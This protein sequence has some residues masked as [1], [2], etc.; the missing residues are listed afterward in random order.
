MYEKLQL[1]MNSFVMNAGEKDKAILKDVLSKIS[2]L[3]IVGFHHK[4]EL[5]AYS[6]S[7]TFDNT[8]TLVTLVIYCYNVGLDIKRERVAAKEKVEVK[9]TDTFTASAYDNNI[10]FL[11]LQIGLYHKQLLTEMN[12]L[13]R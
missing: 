9:R 1:A 4:G 5:E 2:S 11:S 3:T 7:L 12:K 13:N 6:K 10:L 8:A